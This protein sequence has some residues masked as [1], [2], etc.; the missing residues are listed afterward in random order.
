MS[1]VTTSFKIKVIDSRVMINADPTIEAATTN[2]DGYSYSDDCSD[3]YSDIYSDSNPNAAKNGTRNY[4]RIWGYALAAFVVVVIL[5][6]DL[7]GASVKEARV[8]SITVDVRSRRPVVEI[9]LLFKHGSWFSSVQPRDMKCQLDSGEVE[10]QVSKEEG[11]AHHYLVKA[12]CPDEDVVSHANVLWEILTKEGGVSLTDLVESG[13]CE[14]DI[15]LRLGY[16]LPFRHSVEMPLEKFLEMDPGETDHQDK[17]EETDDEGVQPFFANVCHVDKKTLDVCVPLH[18]PDSSVSL[19]PS[20]LRFKIPALQFNAQPDSTAGMMISMDAWEATFDPH[21]EEDMVNGSMAVLSFSSQD[22]N[23]PFYRPIMD[24]LMADVNSTTILVNLDGEESFMEILL[25][26]HHEFSFQHYRQDSGDFQHSYNS[27]QLRNLKPFTTEDYL[28]EYN[29]AAAE[30]I[31]VSDD[32][33]ALGFGFCWLLELLEERL[34]LAGNM[35]ISDWSMLAFSGISW[36]IDEDNL[37]IDMGGS[38]FVVGEEDLMNLLGQAIFDFADDGT[39]QVDLSVENNG[40]LWPFAA[41]IETTSTA[42]EEAQFKMDIDNLTF[43]VDGDGIDAASGGMSMNWDED[44][45]QSFVMNFR[46]DHG[47]TDFVSAQV[48][49]NNDSIFSLSGSSVSDWENEKIWD[50]SMEFQ[51]ILDSSES[52]SGSINSF[53]KDTVSDR[54]VSFVGSL[55]SNDMGSILNGKLSNNQEDFFEIRFEVDDTTL[56]AEIVHDGSDTIAMLVQWPDGIESENGDLVV[57]GNSVCLWDEEYCW[58]LD[59]TFTYKGGDEESDSEKYMVEMKEAV[60]DFTMDVDAS[61]LYGEID[62]TV[63]RGASDGGLNE[64]IQ[65]D[66]EFD[67]MY[68]SV[69]DNEYYTDKIIATINETVSDLTMNGD[70]VWFFNDDG[71]VIRGSS[72]G[73]LD[74]DIQWDMDFDIMYTSVW[75]NEYFTD[76]I[77]VTINETVSDLTMDGD[78]VLFFNDDEEMYVLSGSSG[79]TMDE[80][81]RWDADLSLTLSYDWDESFYSQSIVVDINEAIAD[82]SMFSESKIINNYD[83]PIV[84][85]DYW[86]TTVNLEDN[87][88]TNSVD[89]INTGWN[90]EDDPVVGVETKIF[91]RQETDIYLDGTATLATELDSASLTLDFDMPMATRHLDTTLGCDFNNDVIIQSQIH[92]WWEDENYADLTSKMILGLQEGLLLELSSIDQGNID[93]AA[94]FTT[95]IYG[96]D[97]SMGASIEKLLFKSKADTFVDFYMSMGLEELNSGD[98]QMEMLSESNEEADLQ[99]N[100]NVSMSWIEE[101]ESLSVLADHMFLGWRETMFLE[102]PMRP[103]ENYPSSAPSHS[104]TSA[105]SHIPTHIVSDPEESE[106]FSYSGVSIRL[107]GMPAL[108]NSTRLAFEEGTEAFYDE[109]YQIKTNRRLESDLAFSFFNTDVIVIDD[110]PDLD[111]NTI[112]YDQTITVVSTATNTNVDTTE[113]R[114]SLVLPLMV[115]SNKEKYLKSL[116]ERDEEFSK[117]SEVATPD[118]P[119][120]N[121]VDKVDSLSA[122]AIAGIVLALLFVCCI[123]C[124]SAIYFWRKQQHNTIDRDKTS[125][126]KTLIDTDS[127]EKSDNNIENSHNDGGDNCQSIVDTSKNSIQDEINNFDEKSENSINDSLND[128]SV[129]STSFDP[130]K[131]KSIDNNF[132]E[133]TEND[134][135]CKYNDDE[136]D[137]ISVNSTSLHPVKEGSVISTILYPDKDESIMSSNI[138]PIKTLQEAKQ[139]LDDLGYFIGEQEV[140]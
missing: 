39:I 45:V 47:D 139:F 72:D 32:S 80:E 19:L 99:M 54:E 118:V 106:V 83:G 18:L 1:R 3:R 12:T 113:A 82:F 27:K 101:N 90:T 22:G 109:L 76:K 7:I 34:S 56:N 28:E 59:L 86:L 73:G 11:K 23:L 98:V 121:D 44:F 131:D 63:I 89:E 92:Y 129:D 40:A 31:G 66:M 97:T 112:I 16:V 55:D 35:T 70:V 81:E 78:I 52:E 119:V 6:V 29:D 64:N 50:A 42:E 24:L 135:V 104:P 103:A 13:T 105:P 96:D 117:V 49:T 5:F 36:T 37:Q 58:D 69:W 116:V 9:E 30:C 138:D 134:I 128:E 137:H 10:F 115:D 94:N 84:D 62:G 85:F 21:H 15:H 26:Q 43:L 122:G 107:E 71:V 79:G 132:K 4:R 91:I 110:N 77:I 33:D 53:A 125:L 61:F 14:M 102:M 120:S 95:Q 74:E 88:K 65:W 93:F 111:G 8:E 108:T 87:G 46:L 126:T 51:I 2:S 124:G 127:N 57:T 123:C 100:M 38:V 68:T 130:I 48:E 60:S 17:H 25:G 140:V 114:N 20:V 41:K 75:D 136:D 133:K 67:I